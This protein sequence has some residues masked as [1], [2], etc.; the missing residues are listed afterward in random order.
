MA[1]V[2]NKYKW[3]ISKNAKELYVSEITIEV[4]VVF[5]RILKIES[6]TCYWKSKPK[7]LALWKTSIWAAL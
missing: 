3:S 1:V 4:F 5:T 7:S 2:K 6:D